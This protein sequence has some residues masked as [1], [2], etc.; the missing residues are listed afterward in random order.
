MKCHVCSAVGDFA[1]FDA[2]EQMYGIG[3]VHRYFECGVCGCL[4]I[5]HI[6]ED[7]ARYYGSAYY[8]FKPR[9]SGGVY[10]QIVAMRNRYAVL[11]TGW[12]GHALFQWQPT[13]LFDFLGLA[14]GALTMES[15]ILDVGCGSGALIL[16]FREAGFLNASGIDPFVPA[17]IALDGRPLVRRASLDETAGQFDLIMFHHSLEH[18][19]DQVHTLRL[20]RQRLKP[21]GHCIVRVPLASSEAW[22]RYGVDWVQLDAPRHFYLHTLDSMARLAQGAGFECLE[23]RFDSTAF[24]FWGSEQYRRGMALTD[25]RSYAVDPAA[26]V[27]SADELARFDQEAAELNARRQGDQAGFVLRCV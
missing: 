18:M 16:A 27:F 20:A 25:S 22:R 12:L 4:Q 2:K 14:R 23:V 5:E 11:R 1:V 9:P 19:A 13:Q 17:D 3:D 6:P 26:S 7:M 15:A 10:R 8:S 24:Q 21:G